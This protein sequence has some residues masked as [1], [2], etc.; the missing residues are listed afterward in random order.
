MLI[1]GM[2]SPREYRLSISQIKSHAFF[3]GYNWRSVREN[4][5]PFIPKLLHKCDVSNFDS[6]EDD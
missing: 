5:P 3:T 1:L 6:F 4:V 2:L